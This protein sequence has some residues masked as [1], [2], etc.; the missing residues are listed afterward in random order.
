MLN[1]IAIKICNVLLYNEYYLLLDHF[2]KHLNIIIK[3]NYISI[4]PLK[5]DL[6]LKYGANKII[7]YFACELKMQCSFDYDILFKYHKTCNSIKIIKF[8]LKNKITPTYNQ[9]DLLI[10]HKHFRTVKLLIN[11]GC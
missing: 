9:I 2:I 1:N 7:N 3:P 6:A 8:L 11:E 4:N 5:Y 10:A